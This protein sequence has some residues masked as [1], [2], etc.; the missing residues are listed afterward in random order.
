VP[1][2]EGI[3]AGKLVAGEQGRLPVQETGFGD[4]DDSPKLPAHLWKNASGHTQRL[5]S[6]CHDIG[7]R[8]AMS[9]SFD[10]S[11]RA[12][13]GIEASVGHHREMTYSSRRQLGCEATLPDR[14][15]HVV[16][17]VLN[18]TQGVADAPRYAR[19][20]PTQFVESGGI[21]FA[22]RR[23]G[24]PLL[25]LNYLAANLDKWDPR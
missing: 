21:R 4:R 25:L 12:S 16:S 3:F 15:L 20:H 5:S 23:F 24:R 13:R 9:F 10:P 2:V 11:R 17:R 19:N 22:Y 1:G 8:W 7:E 6:T 18:H 14:C